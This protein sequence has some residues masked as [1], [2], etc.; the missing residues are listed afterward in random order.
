LNNVC[1]AA[2]SFFY[3]IGPSDNANFAKE[4]GKGKFCNPASD[5]KQILPALLLACVACLSA[6]LPASQSAFLTA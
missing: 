4:I 6:C 1:P 5:E 2:A 3:F